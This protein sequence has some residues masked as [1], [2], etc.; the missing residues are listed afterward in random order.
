M[1]K[2]EQYLACYS[3]ST[4]ASFAVYSARLVPS[5]WAVEP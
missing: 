3:G 2:L 4:V 1:D 5:S